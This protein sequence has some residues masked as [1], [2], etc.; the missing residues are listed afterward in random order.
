M[1]DQK[2]FFYFYYGSPNSRNALQLVVGTIF[3]FNSQKIFDIFLIYAD[4][5]YIINIIYSKSSQHTK[6]YFHLKITKFSFVC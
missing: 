2:F 6:I 4:V 5:S 3:F 1:A